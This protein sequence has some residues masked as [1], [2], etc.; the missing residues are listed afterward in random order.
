[1][2]GDLVWYHRRSV[3]KEVSDYLR[4]SVSGFR[5]PRDCVILLSLIEEALLI[6]HIVLVELSPLTAFARTLLTII[7][8]IL[9]SSSCY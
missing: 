4:T 2:S 7:G 8:G 9:V 5:D 1:M 6:E 3:W